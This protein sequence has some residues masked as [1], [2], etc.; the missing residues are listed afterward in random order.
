[1]YRPAV[2]LPGSNIMGFCGKLLAIFE[3]L[4]EVSLNTPAQLSLPLYL[5]T[6]KPLQVSGRGITPLYWL[7]AKRAASGT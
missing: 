1:M 3:I 2:L 6:T 5:L 7:A 4:V